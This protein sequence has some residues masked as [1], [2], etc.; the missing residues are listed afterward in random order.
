VTGIVEM[1]RYQAH[2][3]V[4]ALEIAEICDNAVSFKDEGFDEAAILVDRKMFARYT[5]VAG[6]FLVEYADGYQSFSPRKAFL[7]GYTRLL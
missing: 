2:K 4:A 1:P 6:D 3:I 5:P 7:D